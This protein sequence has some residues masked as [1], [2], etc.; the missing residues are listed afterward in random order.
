MIAVELEA[1]QIPPPADLGRQMP[2]VHHREF[3]VNADKRHTCVAATFDPGKIDEIVNR[4]IDRAFDAEPPLQITQY[5]RS[6]TRLPLTL[7][8][9][10]RIGFDE[11]GVRT[12]HRIGAEEQR[13]D[14]R[15][16]CERNGINPHMRDSRQRP[17]ILCPA[18][19][20]EGEHNQRIRL[21]RIR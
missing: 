16:D 3:L 9:N 2:V 11:I 17:Q 7:R 14:A 5:G 13:M 18:V 8:Q 4:R 19:G 15:R 1:I 6:I 12:G 20:I 21:F 10:F